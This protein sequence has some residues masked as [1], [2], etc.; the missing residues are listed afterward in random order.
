M[1][2]DKLPP[3]HRQAPKQRVVPQLKLASEMQ[4]TNDVMFLVHGCVSVL[5]TAPMM[6]ARHRAS[7]LFALIDEYSDNGKPAHTPEEVEVEAGTLRN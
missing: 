3:T 1:T 2:N 7:V 4:G 5:R 6:A